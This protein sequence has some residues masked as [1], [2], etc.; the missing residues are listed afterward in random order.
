MNMVRHPNRDRAIVHCLRHYQEISR[1]QP[2][3]VYSS[4]P[5]R[6]FGDPVLRPGSEEIVHASTLPWTN[7]GHHVFG[8][9]YTLFGIFC[10]N[11]VRVH[12][13]QHCMGL[14][15][16]RWWNWRYGPR[17]CCSSKPP[18][19][20]ADMPK[21]PQFETPGNGLDWLAVAHRMS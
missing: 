15:R 20:R 21:W 4:A 9:L 3:T 1:F 17:S 2:S 16:Q 6:H 7:H 10:I 5:Q 14:E 18:G 13:F 19:Q 12:N 8:L 11:H